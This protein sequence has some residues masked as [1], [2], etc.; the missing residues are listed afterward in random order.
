[1][2]DPKWTFAK[3]TKIEAI[4]LSLAAIGSMFGGHNKERGLRG[5]EIGGGLGIVLG[6]ATAID[7]AR[8]M[9]TRRS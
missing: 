7:A 2:A 1:M 8:N 4:L 9:P 3:S 6:L 5:A